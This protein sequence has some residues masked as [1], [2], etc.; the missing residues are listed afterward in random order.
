MCL[1]H[2]VRSLWH[3]LSA[4]A[5]PTFDYCPSVGV[6]VAGYNEEETIE[7]TLQSLWGTYPRLELIVVDDGSK[8]GMSEAA[9]RFAK[10]HDGVLVMR[11]DDRGG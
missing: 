3:G 2:W 7:S 8:D 6:V 1:W 10:T 4:K 11:R 5:A 9:Q